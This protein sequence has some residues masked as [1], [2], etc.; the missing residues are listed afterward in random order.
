MC[1]EV[2]ILSLM[3]V[4]NALIKKL[5]DTSGHKSVSISNWAKYAQISP[6]Q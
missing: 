2:I 1:P 3:E 5:K 4:W 6:T